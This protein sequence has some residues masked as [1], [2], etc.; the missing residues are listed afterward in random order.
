[1]SKDNTL[2][3]FGFPESLIKEYDNWYLLLRP[4]QVTIGSL[5]LITKHNEKKYSRLRRQSFVE[6]ADIVSDIEKILSSLFKYNKINYLMLMMID[7]E[8][9]YH[10]VPRYKMDINFHGVLFK[11]TGWPSLPDF[12]NI[13]DVTS[14]VKCLLLNKIKNRFD[15]AKY[16]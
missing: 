12:S 8:V 3:K 14:E 6:F 15:N 11:D 5:I 13:N 1:M 9:H 16:S 2:I 7:P 10:I 4:D